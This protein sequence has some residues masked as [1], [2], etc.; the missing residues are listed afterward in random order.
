[1]KDGPAAGANVVVPLWGTGRPLLLTQ[2]YGF[3][4]DAELGGFGVGLILRGR[5]AETRMVE[6]NAF[7]EGLRAREGYSYPQFGAGL[8]YS[9]SWFTARINGYFPLRGGDN[10]VAHTDRWTNRETRLDGSVVGV[11]W[12]CDSIEHRSP[13]L[14]FDAE[15][16]FR[17][18]DPPKW[19]D[20][21]LVVGYFYREAD[22]RS[23]V[24][25][26]MLVRGELHLGRNWELQGEWRDDAAEIGQE[27]RVVLRWQTSFGG[28][29]GAAAGGVVSSMSYMDRAM[30]GPVEREPWP[31]VTRPVSHGN[32]K[33]GPARLI[34]GPV[35]EG[36]PPADPDDCCPSSSTPLIFE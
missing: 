15:L 22:D 31:T 27:Y 28:P 12:S 1:M 5:L 14:G 35:E 34:S 20:P 33:K 4:G 10:R 9:E 29:E 25:S 13:G 26:G 36:T 32:F 3:K 23:A 21:H 17:L 8:A 16:E 19:I 30:L 24:H 18:P 6:A 7:I 11:D 2:A